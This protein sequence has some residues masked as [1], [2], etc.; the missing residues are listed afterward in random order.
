MEANVKISMG[1]WQKQKAK[2]AEQM[3]K[4]KKQMAFGIG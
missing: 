4:S 2:G 1:K 3:A